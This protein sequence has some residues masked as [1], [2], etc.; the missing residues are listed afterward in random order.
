MTSIEASCA[1]SKLAAS[2]PNLAVAAPAATDA[3]DSKDQKALA[4]R[5]DVPANA[6]EEQAL[7]AFQSRVGTTCAP[8]LRDAGTLLRFLRARE[9]DQ[10]KAYAMWQ[11]WVRWRDDFKLDT[12][13]FPLLAISLTVVL[14]AE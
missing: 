8:R 3:A 5:E 11:K 2:P 14:Q 4:V 10:E 6:A 7:K 1:D 12:S 9:L 13:D